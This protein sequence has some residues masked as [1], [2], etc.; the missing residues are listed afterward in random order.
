MFNAVLYFKGTTKKNSNPRWKCDGDV[1]SSEIRNFVLSHPIWSLSSIKQS[2]SALLEISRD[3]NVTL[4]HR[5]LLQIL[6]YK[7]R[8]R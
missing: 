6:N 2:A 5:V 3:N 1:D 4:S 8:I 7:K